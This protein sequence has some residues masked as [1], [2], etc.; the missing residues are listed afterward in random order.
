MSLRIFKIETV[1]EGKGV[2]G[3]RACCC[4]FRASFIRATVFQ[5][6]II[7]A[8]IRAYINAVNKIAFT[9]RLENY[10]VIVF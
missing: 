8:S 6:D 5:A 4:A 3:Q 2:D 9:G 7:G 1:T 10:E